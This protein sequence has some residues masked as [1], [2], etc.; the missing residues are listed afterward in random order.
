MV[1]VSKFARVAGHNRQQ[2]A[3]RNKALQI[4]RQL[5][6]LGNQHYIAYMSI[7]QPKEEFVHFVHIN[8]QHILLIYGL[9]LGDLSVGQV[10]GEIHSSNNKM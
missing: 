3:P 5:D 7:G 6:S 1:R 4:H 9:L 2:P 10:Q 8:G